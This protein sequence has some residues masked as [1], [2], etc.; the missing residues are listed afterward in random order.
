MILLTVFDTFYQNLLNST[1]IE[2]VAVIFGLLSVWYCKKE[3]ILV[4]PTGIVSVLIYVYICYYAKLYADMGINFY[5]FVMSVI[6]WY[7]WTRKTPDNEETNTRPVSRC[8]K[9]E[10]I[11]CIVG[12]ILSFIV[13]RFILVNYTDSNVPV[14]DSITTSL[15]FLA[16]W[17]QAKKKIETWIL[18]ILGDVVSVPLYFYKHLVFTSFQFFVFLIIAVL[19]YIEWQKS[20]EKQKAVIL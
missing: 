4:Y 13:L 18:W 16:M 11:I 8:T 7:M 5:Y 12:L 9:L 10:Y 6:G 20:I 17:L 15:F 2:I 3:N 1:W 14:W 19:G